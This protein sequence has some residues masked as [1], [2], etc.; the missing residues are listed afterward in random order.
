MMAS[1][2]SDKT[3][4]KSIYHGTQKLRNKF[5]RSSS[6]SQYNQS[7]HVSL[8]SGGRNLSPFLLVPVFGFEPKLYRF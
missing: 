6:A 3:F 2:D 5:Q 8:T 4:S 1:F 7:R